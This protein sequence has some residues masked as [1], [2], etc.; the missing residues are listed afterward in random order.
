M[1]VCVCVLQVLHMHLAM[2]A[3]PEDAA[4]VGMLH[5][6]HVDACVVQRLLLRLCVCVF[7]GGGQH[8]DCCVCICRR[9]AEVKE[10]AKAK[11]QLIRLL[12]REPGHPEVRVGAG[13]GGSC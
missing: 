13:C 2:R 7:W 1:C 6:R 9:A 3:V 5:F 4:H 12:K 10:T 11:Q 8:A